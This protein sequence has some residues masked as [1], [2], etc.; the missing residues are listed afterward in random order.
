MDLS[1]SVRQGVYFE[2]LPLR[3]IGRQGTKPVPPLNLVGGLPRGGMLL[4]FVFVC[5]ISVLVCGIFVLVCG[6]SALVCGISVLVCGILE[7]QEIWSGP[8]GRCSHGR[9]CRNPDGDVLQ[10]EV[11]RSITDERGTNLLDGGAHFY[12]TCETS[13]GKYVSVG[14]IEPLFYAL[15]LENA[16]RTQPAVNHGP[17]RAGEDSE[18]V[19]RDLGLTD[20]EIELLVEAGVV[21]V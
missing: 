8:G 15:L 9:W 19:L 17:R 11:R 10:H 1:K 14:S 20:D 13:D 18:S 3:G 21:G 4:A 5:G 6:I 16:G 2:I 12:N 7:T